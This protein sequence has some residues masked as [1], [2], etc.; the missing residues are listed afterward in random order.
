MIY[1]NILG[2]NLSREL[3]N[4]IYNN[5]KQEIS[6]NQS[7]IDKVNASEEQSSNLEAADLL[8]YRGEKYKENRLKLKEEL[9][10]KEF[11]E[12][13]FKPTLFAKPKTTTS[14]YAKS[15]PENSLKAIK[16]KMNGA[17]EKYINPGQK[18]H[19]DIKPS[20]SENLATRFQQD[21]GQ[22]STTVN[23]T[24]S[25]R[26]PVEEKLPHDISADRCTPLDR[27]TPSERLNTEESEPKSLTRYLQNKVY[28]NTE[29]SMSNSGD[30]ASPQQKGISEGKSCL[31]QDS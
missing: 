13:T 12:C 17:L 23:N 7:K 10:K 30:L 25:E 15:K 6:I 20:E 26:H 21:N 8:L 31:V 4:F 5:L 19:R 18:P 1:L 29:S 2:C 24:E 22:Q 16:Y 14:N 27:F 3:G 28:I 11:D 9:S